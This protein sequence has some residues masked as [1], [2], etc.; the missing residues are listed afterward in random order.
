MK[1]GRKSEGALQRAQQGI[2]FQE[3]SYEKEFEQAK[4]CYR[5]AVRL[6]LDIGSIC[7]FCASPAKFVGLSYESGPEGCGAR[8]SQL[9]GSGM[10]PIGRP[11]PR[12]LTSR[13]SSGMSVPTK[14]AAISRAICTQSCTAGHSG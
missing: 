10:P 11:V 14:Q 13:A 8:R 4:F 7:P 6:R 1:G 12:F 2:P 9:S 5:R 3:I